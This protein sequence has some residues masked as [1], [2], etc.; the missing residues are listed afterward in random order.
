M[1]FASSLISGRLVQR[2]KRVLARVAL[3][4]G[5]TIT[6][7]Y[8]N[9]SLIEGLDEPGALVYL[10]YNLNP[11]RKARYVLEL[12][13]TKGGLVALN[14]THNIPLLA[15]AI[16]S[17]KIKELANYRDVFWKIDSPLGFSSI[18]LLL[19]NNPFKQENCYVAINNIFFKRKVLAVFP[20]NISVG[21]QKQLADLDKI[22]KEG[23]RAVLLLLVKRMDCLSACLAWDLDPAYAG[24]LIDLLERGVDVV[25]YSCKISLKSIVIDQPMSILNLKGNTYNE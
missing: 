19:A 21:A 1:L 7:Y 17:N 24:F 3:E 13:E 18:D 9:F 22:V 15:E 11:Q 14:S 12:I 8:P 10:S 5:R 25:C 4:D 6:A 20:D 23:H 16:I 2:E